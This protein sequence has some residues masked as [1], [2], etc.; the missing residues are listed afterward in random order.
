MNIGD[1]LDAQ[2]LGHTAIDIK[3]LLLEHGYVM[4]QGSSAKLP[5]LPPEVQA[6]IAALEVERE[7]YG[8]LDESKAFVCP[9]C[10][11]SNG[12]AWRVE[13]ATGTEF[14]ACGCCHA[15]VEVR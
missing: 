12:A 9:Y 4:P 6:A 14:L 3:G 8:T 5:L 1:K 11:E 15:V 13:V 7:K 2:A 10:E